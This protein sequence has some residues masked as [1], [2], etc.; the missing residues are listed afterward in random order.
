ML[1]ADIARVTSEEK[2]TVTM[3]VFIS[4]RQFGLIIGTLLCATLSD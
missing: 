2:R 4:M 3:S 1:F